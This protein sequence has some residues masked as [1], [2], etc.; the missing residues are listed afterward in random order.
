MDRGLEGLIHTINILDKIGLKHIGTY[1]A[2]S[3]R[4]EACYLDNGKY[5]VAVIAYTYGTNYYETKIKLEDNKLFHINLLRPQEESCYIIKDKKTRKTIGDSITRFIPL[6]KK[7]AIK[8][9]LRK[10][11][12]NARSDDNLNIESSAQYI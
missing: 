6:E 4:S 1:D 12:N 5:R 3:H 2:P 9:M 7:I 11:Y 10:P 8:K